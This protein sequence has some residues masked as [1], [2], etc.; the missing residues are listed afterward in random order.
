MRKLSSILVTGGA[1]FIGSNFI[2]HILEEPEFK[3]RIVN[4]DALTYAGNSENLS[5]IA[6][7]HGSRHVFV[8]GDIR[9]KASV[10]KVFA[11]F[12]IDAVVHFAAESHVDRSILG[13]EDFITT[14]VI[15]QNF[16]QL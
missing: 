11:D 10:E 2:R 3:G 16:A 1:G 15:A 12:A 6:A 14:N 13:P 8:R 4:F 5:D 7:Q 9:E